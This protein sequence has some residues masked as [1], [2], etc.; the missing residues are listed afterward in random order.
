MYKNKTKVHIRECIRE[1]RR[2]F[3]LLDMLKLND[4]KTKMMIFSS[5]HHLKMYGGC[6][7]TIGDDT[8]SLS[9]RIRNL[10]V[11]MDQHMSMTVM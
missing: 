8:D 5:K 11:H 9:H 6:S 3:V 7:L 2:R 1:V 10:G 4:E